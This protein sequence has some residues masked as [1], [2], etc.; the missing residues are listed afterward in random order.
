MPLLCNQ[1]DY[2]KL[3]MVETGKKKKKSQLPLVIFHVFLNWGIESRILL[4]YKPLSLS[5]HPRDMNHFQPPGPFP[6]T[7]ETSSV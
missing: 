5:H 7:E 2:F 3:C 4:S 1:L 6:H